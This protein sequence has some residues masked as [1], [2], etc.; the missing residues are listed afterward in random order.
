MSKMNSQPTPSYAG[1][2]R[3]KGRDMRKLV[4]YYLDG[5][6]YVLGFLAVQASY[7]SSTQQVPAMRLHPWAPLGLCA[8][9]SRVQ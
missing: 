7:H 9:G 1:V 3:E 5:S 6:G 8:G 2:F 4:D